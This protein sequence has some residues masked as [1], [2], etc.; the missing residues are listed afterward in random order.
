M[1]LIQNP[2]HH[3][4][5][6]EKQLNNQC[7]IKKKLKLCILRLRSSGVCLSNLMAH[8]PQKPIFLGLSWIIQMFLI[9]KYYT[10]D[11]FKGTNYYL[12][13]NPASL[14]SELFLWLVR[15]LFEFLKVDLF[16]LSRRSLSAVICL[17]V[18]GAQNHQTILS[19]RTF[20]RKESYLFFATK[21]LLVKNITK[22]SL[23]FIGLVAWFNLCWPSFNV[24]LDQNR[25]KPC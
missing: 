21:H 7:Y 24:K 13:C 25:L 15:W 19:Y 23:Y 14:H 10:M 18:V 5:P 17:K 11:T 8:D 2:A 12:D 1:I 22:S 20:G 6:K 16:L 3:K 4:T 9:W